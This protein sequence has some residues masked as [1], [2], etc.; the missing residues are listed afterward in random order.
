MPQTVAPASRAGKS[1]FTGSIMPFYDKLCAHIP[2]LSYEVFPP[3]NPLEWGALYST[4]GQIS[5][6]A[7]DFISVT[8]RGGVSTRERTVELVGRI[9]RE[10]AIETMAHLTCISHSAEELL[11]IM[12]QLASSGVRNIIALRGDR[13]KEKPAHG[14]EHASDFI[15]LA[16]SRFGG[17][18][19][20]AYHPEKHPESASLDDDVRYLKL[21]EESGADFAI[22][23]FFFDNEEFFRFRDKARTAGVTLPLLVGI[24]PID[25]ISQL[26]RLA[27]MS[28]TAV[29]KKLLD[30]LGE[31]S[32]EQISQR[33]VEYSVAQSRELLENGAAG[34][35]LYTLNKSGAAVKISKGLRALGYFPVEP[36]K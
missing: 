22:S 26:P 21:K 30:F 33:G 8:Y 24:M 5:R 9:Q 17:R 10:L 25:S 3:K 7:P 35:H 23:Q 28:G 14:M 18:I 13:P 29:P 2:T 34:I 19:A 6:Q 11:E 12:D 27:Q 16:K 20:C 15:A 4:L 31:G 1:A 32:P 36:K